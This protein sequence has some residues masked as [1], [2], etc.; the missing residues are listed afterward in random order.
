MLCAIPFDDNCADSC[1]R[2]SVAICMSENVTV[3]INHRL[4]KAE[5]VRRLK[6]GLTH[7]SQLGS[8][9]AIDQATWQ[10]DTLCFSMRALGQSAAASIE[11]LDD[12]LRIEVSLP[13]LLA[14]VVKRLIPILRKEATALLAKK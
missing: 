7:T 10:G 6:E 8:M 3:V 1:L 12:A 4:G 11:V 2:Y 9:I 13:G 14:K 5:A